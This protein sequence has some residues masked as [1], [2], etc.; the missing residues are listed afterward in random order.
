MWFWCPR[1][2]YVPDIACSIESIECN[3]TWNLGMLNLLPPTQGII[4]TY[5]RRSKNVLHVFWMFYVRSVYT[6]FQWVNYIFVRTVKSYLNHTSYHWKL[7][8]SKYF[9]ANILQAYLSLI[10]FFAVLTEIF[11]SRKFYL[12]SLDVNEQRKKQKQQAI[13]IDWT[14]VIET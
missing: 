6:L 13:K 1:E 8:L 3:L 9:H 4:W 11:S 7:F 5:I 2:R 12:P 10:A 14:P